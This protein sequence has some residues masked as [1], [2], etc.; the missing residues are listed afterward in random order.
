MSRRTRTE[1]STDEYGRE[2]HPSF[3]W[4]K[5]NRV[6]VSP[7]GQHLFDSELRHSEMVVLSISGASR[8]RELHRDWLME[9]GLPHVE[10]AMSMAQWG[11]LVSS[12]GSSG[13]PATLRFLDGDYVPEAPYEPRMALS[14]AEVEDATDKLLSEVSEAVDAVREAY[15]RKA[16]RREMEP[17]LRN[18]EIKLSNAKPNARFTAQSFTEHVENVVTKARADI[19]GMVAMAADHQLE[20]GDVAKSLGMGE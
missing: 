11:A 13:V 14:T 8:K 5:V 15:D 6:T 4:A 19:E 3:G 20:T 1:I 9:E 7:P 17:L 18:L 10:I 2:V 12:F 16:G